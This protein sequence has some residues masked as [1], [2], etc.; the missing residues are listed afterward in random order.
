MIPYY[1]YS[2]LSYAYLGFLVWMLIDC[3]RRE[4]DR[5]IWMLVMFLLQPL[6]VIAYFFARFLPRGHAPGMNKLK[7]KFQTG[8]VKRLQ[9]A[10]AQI[11]NAYHW[12]QYADRLSELSRWSQAEDAYRK[13][14]DR[15][16]DNL[17]AQWGLAQ[18]L[19]K[20]QR[21]AE[22]LEL[23]ESILAQDASYKFGDVS[24]AKGRLLGKLER[25]EPA[26][27]H[28][29]QHVLRWRQPE[30]L[31]WLATAEKQLGE[32]DAARTHLQELIMDIEASPPAIARK[33]SGWKRKA[34]SLLKSL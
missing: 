23:T 3:Y 20:Q 13:A 5:G 11:G 1:L 28:L 27:D 18:C 33:Q 15:E 6:G 16:P 12:I 34:K 14:L 30:G 19:D 8:D 4:P 32:T 22:S 24:L 7:S 17:Q 10:A 2:V 21:Y 29:A 26:R 31:Y 9:I 25:W